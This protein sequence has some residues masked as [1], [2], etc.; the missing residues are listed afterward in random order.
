VYV[1]V[2]HQ[3]DGNVTMLTTNRQDGTVKHSSTIELRI[4]VPP[5]LEL[6]N[7]LN[8]GV[9]AISSAELSGDQSDQ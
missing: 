1:H 5:R 2:I 7:A 9:V 3:I 4:I 6:R 8:G